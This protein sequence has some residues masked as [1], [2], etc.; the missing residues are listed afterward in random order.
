[1]LANFNPIMA[2]VSLGFDSGCEELSISFMAYSVWFHYR[3][4]DSLSGR[5]GALRVY[6][7]VASAK[8][9]SN[10]KVLLPFA[11]L[12]FVGEEELSHVSRWVGEQNVAG[13]TIGR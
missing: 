11:S 1:M 8:N 6:R 7:N 10:Q 9:G 13:E 5:S 4:S 12:V 2:Q 3:L